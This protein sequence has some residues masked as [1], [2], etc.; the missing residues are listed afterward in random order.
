[1]DSLHKKLHQLTEELQKAKLDIA[2]AVPPQSGDGKK[3]AQPKKK[4]PSIP[5]SHIDS[6]DHPSHIR[7][8]NLKRLIKD[9]DEDDGEEVCKTL[10]N[11]QWTLE[12]AKN[13]HPSHEVPGTPLSVRL[14]NK[15]HDI[16]I[17][18]DVH[19]N[20][21]R[22]GYMRY[23]EGAPYGGHIHP[24]HEQHYNAVESHL[25]NGIQSGKI[26]TK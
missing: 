15:Y 14:S 26:S 24:D 21:K 7:P 8:E 2:P 10:P 18:Y 12:K 16:G 11:G 13:K 25:H 9:E 20:G 23:A 19:H 22:V 17:Q 4:Q 5:P 3:P 1:M 6:E